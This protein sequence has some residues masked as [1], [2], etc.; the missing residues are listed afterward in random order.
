MTG[1]STRA[2]SSEDPDEI[3]EEPG[4]GDED[5]GGRGGRV[6]AK[7]RGD[8]VEENGEDRQRKQADEGRKRAGLGAPVERNDFHHLELSRGV[9]RDFRPLDPF[10]RFRLLEP[11]LEIGRESRA[12]VDAVVE[13]PGR[14]LA[15]PIITR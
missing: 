8:E 12:A 7:K 11:L 2:G 9:G 13:L 1:D 15:A 6:P 14:Q 3:A 4:S 5:Q 10:E